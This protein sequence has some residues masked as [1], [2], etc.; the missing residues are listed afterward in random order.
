MLVGGVGVYIPI[1][2]FALALD[3][4]MTGVWAVTAVR[5]RA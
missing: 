3:W 2:L 4:G 5:V 1:A